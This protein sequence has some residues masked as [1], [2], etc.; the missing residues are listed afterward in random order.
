MEGDELLASVERLG[1]ISRLTC[2]DCHG[3]LWEI[4]DQDVLRYRQIQPHT[5]AITFARR[6]QEA[7]EHSSLI[8]QLLLSDK[9]DDIAEPALQGDD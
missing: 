4:D 2:P 8:R 7:E 3:A 6:A 1:K 5:A 9:K